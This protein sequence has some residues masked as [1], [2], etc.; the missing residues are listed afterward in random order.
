M[1]ARFKG[2]SEREKAEQVLYGQGSVLD[3]LEF[4]F[5]RLLNATHVGWNAMIVEVIQPRDRK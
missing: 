2:L 3:P 1:E 4:S 5:T